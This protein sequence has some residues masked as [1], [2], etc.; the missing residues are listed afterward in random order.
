MKKGKKLDLKVK[1]KIMRA[2]CSIILCIS[3]MCVLY[4]S[5][6]IA[7]NYDAPWNTFAPLLL[8][9]SMIFLGI[10]EILYFV[11]RK[12]NEKSNLD[13][14]YLAYGIVSIVIGFVVLF[15]GEGLI[16][17]GVVSL[18]FLLIPIIKRV[19]AIVKNHK[20]RNII[21]NIILI[22]ICIF[23]VVD[24]CLNLGQTTA[25][26][27]IVFAS[28]TG[29]IIAV[30]CFSNICKIALS[31]INGEILSKI[32][33][34]TYAGEVIL[35]LGLLM[36]AFSLILRTVEDSIKT[37][38]D[39]L[40][41][42]FMLVTTIGFGDLTSVTFLG[43][44]LSVVLGLYGLVVVALVTSIIV[45]FYGEVKNKDEEKKSED[46]EDNLVTEDSSFETSEED[47]EQKETSTE[48]C[49]DTS[50]EE[51]EPKVFL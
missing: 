33:R 46:G 17:F 30:T 1:N 32:I 36:I 12:W 5:S 8:A 16:V 48:D 26:A 39:A 47:I 25:S 23:Y 24:I 6:Q 9:L 51:S 21:C 43:R 44:V 40:W 49:E 42:C 14:E 28:S 20:A 11:Y 31:H 18:L 37:F 41:Y 27:Y 22:A 38:W 15:F 3:L 45:N 29:I 19:L 2:V 7:A 4:V 35:G 13:Y 34:K 10:Y 50:V